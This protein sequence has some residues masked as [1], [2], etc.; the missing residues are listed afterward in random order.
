MCI[1]GFCAG[2]CVSARKP[3]D[4]FDGSAQGQFPCE[5]DNN[6]GLVDGVIEC[7]TGVHVEND[8]VLGVWKKQQRGRVRCAVVDVK[9]DC[10][11]IHNDS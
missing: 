6:E 4:T 2:E 1:S 10:F 7:R 8:V 9:N 5:I 3:K 11:V